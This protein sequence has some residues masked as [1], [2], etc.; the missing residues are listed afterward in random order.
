MINF[1]VRIN[2]KKRNV[3]FKIDK[4]K[5]VIPSKMF[6]LINPSKIRV[7]SKENTTPIKED[8]ETLK[9]IMQICKFRAGYCYYNAELFKEVSKNYNVSNI[10]VYSGWL[11]SSPDFPVYH[12]WVVV[13]DSI[14][15]GSILRDSFNIL[16]KL[17]SKLNTDV[18]NIRVEYGRILKDLLNSSS[19]NNEK[20]IFGQI[21][22][23]L[24]YVGCPSSADEAR[25][26]FKKLTLNFPNHPAYKSQGMNQY[27]L[28]D[29][30][31]EL[32]K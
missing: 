6:P 21:P 24:L 10:E 15:D 31:Q 18:N 28:S 14:I 5:Y 1:T 32:Y 7:F 9:E 8:I 16:L 26:A 3:H 30:Q 11:F 20:F 25:N 2:E 29:L 19:P 4:S 27:G 12:V 23:N 22:E 17:T 13:N